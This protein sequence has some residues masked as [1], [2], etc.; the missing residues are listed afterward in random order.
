MSTHIEFLKLRLA[1]IEKRIAMTEDYKEMKV[2]KRMI[3]ELEALEA[4]AKQSD[5]FEKKKDKD[6]TV[7]PIQVE[8]KKRKNVY[9]PSRTRD[10]D[11]SPVPELPRGER[12]T[13]IYEA[14]E[15]LLKRN[16]RQMDVKEIEQQL[17][18]KH[19]IKWKKPAS[20]QMYIWSYNTTHP[21]N[22]T[23]E[24]LLEARPGQNRKLAK[25]IKYIGRQRL[26]A[27]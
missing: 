5:E 7:W 27:V 9:D 18:I 11:N 8:K 12:M 2:L 16:G 21:E 20:I 15:A 14:T 17:D 6:N 1:T 10:E 3:A 13:F 25:Y 23:L 22:E 4:A 24:V 26:S 19:G